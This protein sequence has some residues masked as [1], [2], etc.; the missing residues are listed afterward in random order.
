MDRA[1]SQFAALGP[2]SSLMISELRGGSAAPFPGFSTPQEDSDNCGPVVP[3]EETP[4]EISA[5]GDYSSEYIIVR[6]TYKNAS[7]QTVTRSWSTNWLYYNTAY[8][9]I[10]AGSSDARMRIMYAPS[11]YAAYFYSNCDGFD[12]GDCL[13][14]LDGTLKDTV[15]GIEDYC[16]YEDY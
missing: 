1:D 16:Y 4:V 8:H 9:T 7:N 15:V 12:N 5:F 2:I 11:C 13:I 3:D 10:P 6:L 14:T